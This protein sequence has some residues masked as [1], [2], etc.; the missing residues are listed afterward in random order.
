MPII[1]SIHSI[2]STHRA[3][4][5]SSDTTASVPHDNGRPTPQNTHNTP[6]RSATVPDSETHGANASQ[7]SVPP[8]YPTTQTPP[9]P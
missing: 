8:P 4:R 1:H 9:D 7:R 5:R 2:H 3:A 6:P